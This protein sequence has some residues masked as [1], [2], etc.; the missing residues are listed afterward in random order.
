MPSFRILPCLTAL[1]LAACGTHPPHDAHPGG[2]TAVAS[3]PAARQRLGD[4]L[5]LIASQQFEAGLAALR[6][7]I[8]ARSFASLPSDDRYHA[9]VAAGRAEMR[10]RRWSRARG[11]MSRAATMPQATADDRVALVTIGSQLHDPPLI[12]E[13][14]TVVARNWPDRLGKFDEDYLTRVLATQS[15]LPR[16]T[17][18]ALLQSLY[19][20]NF[21]LNWDIEPS[22]SWRDLMLLL[23]EQGRPSDA[24]D[25]SARI[26]DPLV[27]IE[28]RADRRFDTVVAAHPERFDAAAAADRQ[29]EWLQAKDEGGANSLRVKSLLMAALMRRNHASAA[30]AIADDAIAEIR[31]TNYPERR[32]VDYLAEYGNLLTQR[33]AVLIDLGLWDDGAAQLKAAAR[34]FEHDHDNVDAAI[35]LA[36][37]ECD[38]ARPADARS[39]LAQITASLSPYGAMQVEDVRLDAATQE[40]DPAQVERSLSYLRAHRGDAPMTYLDAL[41]VADRLDGAAEELRRQLED[42]VTRQEALGDVQ[43]YTLQ[44]ATPRDLEMRARWQSVLARA[45]VQSAIARV[46][47]VVGYDL[48]GAPF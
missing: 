35:D 29:I 45:D 21:K 26:T 36:Q 23:I 37:I 5:R 19:A 33:A 24:V 32:F 47:R 43:T 27:L 34:E 8:D 20:A 2:Q 13:S 42:P 14:L 11:Y 41:L 7:V 12:A 28:I 38:L 17:A 44:R 9:L 46:G 48:E 1:A 40:N 3:D 18:L 30:L 31:D 16:A 22:E 25:V 10:F 39:V 6:T 4:A 15:K